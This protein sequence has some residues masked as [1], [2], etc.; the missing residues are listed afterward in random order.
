MQRRTMIKNVL[1]GL[2]R[3]DY[4]EFIQRNEKIEKLKYHT[5]TSNF[6]LIKVESFKGE[7]WTKK[8]EKILSVDLNKFV[9]DGKDTN[10]M[11]RSISSVEFLRIRSQHYDNLTV[12]KANGLKNIST[13]DK[14]LNQVIGN[15]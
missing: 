14:K 12:V 9:Y 15:N 7:I 10:V 6:S 3:K 8:Q 11:L 5:N 2:L 1:T 4:N 13:T